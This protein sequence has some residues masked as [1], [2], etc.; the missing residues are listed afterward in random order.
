MG[1]GLIVASVFGCGLLV[2]VCLHD[3][4]GC[5]VFGCWI[6][7][8]GVFVFAALVLEGCLLTYLLAGFCVGVNSV[9][10]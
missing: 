5:G 10:I 2:V 6:S 7:G 8:V 9:G 1:L 4:L 3:C